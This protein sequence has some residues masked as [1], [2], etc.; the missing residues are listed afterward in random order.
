MAT[1][2]I[3]L[4]VD[5]SKA[6]R[7][8][9]QAN[10]ALESIWR[11]A[12]KGQSSVER[13]MRAFERQTELMGKTGAARI[14]AMQQITQRQFAGDP[15]AIERVTRALSGMAAMQQTVDKTTGQLGNRLRELVQN[16]L[17]AAGNAVE[18]LTTK[19]GMM[20]AIIMGTVAAV[21]AFAV[22][23][24]K[25][26][27]SL[28][29]YGDRIGDTSIRLGMTTKEVG[30]FDFAMKRAGGSIEGVEG[31]MR[32][33]SQALVTTP[34]E[35]GKL[36]IRVRELD[37]SFRP[38]TEIIL[39]L[40]KRLA[41][42]PSAFERNAA[43]V[44][45]MGR[46]ALEALPD[47][48]QLAE[49]VKRAR[50]LDVGLTSAQVK[51]FEE[52]QAQIAEVEHA[53]EK[54]KRAIK[55]PIAATFSLIIKK[56]DESHT[57]DIGQ[58]TAGDVGMDLALRSMGMPKN[59]RITD[60]VGSRLAEAQAKFLESAR[61]AALPAM[62]PQ[63]RGQIERDIQSTKYG[64][65][66]SLSA[67]KAKAADAYKSYAGYAGPDKNE[68]ARLKETYATAERSATG[69]QKRM[70]ALTEA[71]SKAKAATEKFKNALEGLGKRAEESWAGGDE[72][73]KIIADYQQFMGEFKP[74]GRDLENVNALFGEIFSN[75]HVEIS[76]KLADSWEKMTREAR[77]L[78]EE[79]SKAGWKEYQSFLDKYSTS[80]VRSTVAMR[81][82]GIS[83][84]A[85]DA[86]A[87]ARR[88]IQVAELMVA[89]GREGTA[90]DYA[91]QRQKQLAQELYSIEKDR[92][93]LET[94]TWKQRE[95]NFENE[96]RFK[97]AEREADYGHEIGMLELQKRRFDEI[98]SSFENL[99]DTMISNS[100]NTWDTLKRTFLSIFLTPIKR[101]LSTMVA[102]LFAG[103]RGTAGAGSWSGALAGIG[104]MF[105]GG[106][107]FGGGVPG[108]GGFG[109]P[110]APG[111]TSGFAGPV[112]GWEAVP[113]MTGLFQNGA[114][115]LA[116]VGSG[117]MPSVISSG[118]T[119]AMGF[120][121]KFGGAINSGLMMGGLGLA[122]A[123]IQRKNA[124]MT[125]AGGAAMGFGLAGKMGMTG[126]GGAITGAGA[127][128][129]IAGLQ[130]GGV[131]GLA[132]STGGAALVGLQFGGPLGAA[133]GAGI[134][135][136]AGMV[137]L[138]IKGASEKLHDKIRAV[139]GVDVTQKNI[140][141]QMLSIIKQNYGGNLDVGVR[142]QP[143][144]DLIELYA[145]STGKSM[146]VKATMQPYSYSQAGGALSQQ[147]VG[148]AYSAPASIDNL[149]G[150][151]QANGVGGSSTIILQVDSQAIGSVVLQNGRVVAAAGLRAMKAN[152][153]R[154]ETTATQLS[155]G[156]LTA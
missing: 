99:F 13:T 110:G 33:L 154:R 8:A 43:A 42:M 46:G 93:A 113:G 18:A 53:W 47:L 34:E 119:A 91:A 131:S 10:R 125:I 35:F 132:M 48:L 82:A 60:I 67:A 26:A 104:G 135:L 122:G 118:T 21:A 56:W 145:M 45:L 124:G 9:D 148:G 58:I 120:G 66:E 116:T 55:E 54:L 36:G 32:K 80:V 61:A 19:A 147:P 11:S 49:G 70:D 20:G 100:K 108:L 41:S 130:R 142:S 4:E 141:Q 106:G 134:G 39:E 152:S 22:V 79:M 103:Q 23:G 127:G 136:I 5:P 27:K 114:G 83:G 14:A 15:A 117:G 140:L 68:A 65:G 81:E 44:K 78:S 57:K 63:L 92:I 138:F 59:V 71:E 77:G 3:V 64:L 144:R 73:Q 40:S 133:I 88:D 121:G 72:L 30:Q 137:R 129:A 31:V 85:T 62:N 50:D 112:G 126:Y 109:L 37:G 95:M 90:V 123:G 25:A 149:R 102:N 2:T 98:R 74:R 101:E 51:K 69:L 1:E 115:Q 139:Y 153:G 84:L 97:R 111:G 86:E 38:T 105:R 24:F 128:V 75:K 150:I 155:P 52:Y 89:P 7:G 17:H 6:V 87:R 156:L 94:D 146:A 29:E 28:G 151:T 143:V 16:P 96:A 107:G 12:D 76:D